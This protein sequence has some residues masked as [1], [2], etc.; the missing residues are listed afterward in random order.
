MIKGTGGTGGVEAAAISA[1]M[2]GQLL[3]A[4]IPKLR[5]NVSPIPSY[6]IKL[7]K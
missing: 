4:A 2:L 3:L 1:F 5:M 6:K 7:N